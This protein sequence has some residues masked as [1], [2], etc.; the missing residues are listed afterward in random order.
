M[1][2]SDFLNSEELSQLRGGRKPPPAGEAPGDGYDAPPPTGA[3]DY[4]LVRGA[5]RVVQFSRL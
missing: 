5:P 4:G 3:D 2:A 1:K